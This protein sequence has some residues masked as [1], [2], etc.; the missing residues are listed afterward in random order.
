MKKV[1]EDIKG[2]WAEDDILALIEAGILKAD[3]KKFAPDSKIKQKD[4]IKILISSLQPYYPI[5]PYVREDEGSNEEYEEYYKQ[6]IARKIINEKEKNMEAEIGRAEAAKMIVNAMDLG[7]I[8]KKSEIFN[9]NYKDADKISNELKG[10]AAIVTG[11]D[12]MSGSDGYFSPEVKLTKAETA[13]IIVKFLKV[14]KE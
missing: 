8:A 12:I 10:Y 9:I 2:H 13:S 4:F 7:Y 1:F 11:L 3:S 14:E 5:I 6:A